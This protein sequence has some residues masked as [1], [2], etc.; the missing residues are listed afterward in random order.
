MSLFNKNR[1]SSGG[2][3]PLTE[4]EI[5]RR[6][7]GAY[8][9]DKGNSGI[10]LS[11]PAS[12]TALPP[13]PIATKEK[14]AQPV[15][16]IQDDLFV[17][18]QPKT[19]GEA[20][21]KPPVSAP[22]EISE[23]ERMKRLSEIADREKRRP[24]PYLNKDPWKKN[25]GSPGK[26]SFQSSK[27]A[28]DAFQGIAKGIAA[29]LKF[30][31]GIIVVLLSAALKGIASID[32]R[33][34]EVRRVLYWLTG[35]AVLLSLFAAV[36]MLNVR[37]EAALRTNSTHAE[38]GPSRREAHK[39]N[40]NSEKKPAENVKREPRENKERKE[41]RETKEAT[42]EPAKERRERSDALQPAAK[43][44]TGNETAEAKTQET[45]KPRTAESTEPPVGEGRYVI[46]VATYATTEDA[47]RVV[48]QIKKEG[49]PVFARALGRPGGRIYYA[50][51]IGRFETFQTAQQR[52][53]KFRKKDSSAPFE[54]AF[55]RTLES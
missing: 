36:H 41:V 35:A 38:Q 44:V 7:Y 40:F 6:L 53:E 39:A 37:R 46:Q 8:Q 48:E 12:E 52:L 9:P 1:K 30:V 10:K 22:E 55:I 25:A 28:S 13:R 5:Q 4:D 16:Q 3:R 54:D 43:E 26:P 17:E 49:I 50:V 23:Q 31:F 47:N 45:Q 34:P 42:R 51:F 2:L 32:I 29:A 33:K 19:A 11:K 27:A 14:S 20:A 18:S 24:P 21:V 15:T